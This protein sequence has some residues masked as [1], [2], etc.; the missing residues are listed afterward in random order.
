MIPT[1][2]WLSK[3]PSVS[4]PIQLS[5]KH[6]DARGCEKGKMRNFFHWFTLS[7][8]PVVQSYPGMDHWE[9]AMNLHFFELNSFQEPQ[10][11]GCPRPISRDIPAIHY[12]KQQQS[13]PRMKCLSKTSR[14]WGQ[15]HP[16]IWAPHVPRISCPKTVSFGCSHVSKIRWQSPQTSGALNYKDLRRPVAPKE[17]QWL[18]RRERPLL[19]KWDGKK[20]KACTKNFRWERCLPNFWV[21]MWARFAA[22]PLVLLSI[23]RQNPFTMFTWTFGFVS[24]LRPP[25]QITKGREG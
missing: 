7:G 24:C 22:K 12:L 3:S 25:R 18:F 9:M 23:V 4:T 19:Q 21:N 15:G 8:T 6:V 13:A 11:S 10:L 16:A 5:T 17:R 14:A 1:L 2:P 20:Q